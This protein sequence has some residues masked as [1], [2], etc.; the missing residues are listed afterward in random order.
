MKGLKKGARV[1]AT[2]ELFLFGE[3][4]RIPTP[5]TFGITLF[6]VSAHNDCYMVQRFDLLELFARGK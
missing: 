5:V 2:S 3:E 4:I 1:V 6:C